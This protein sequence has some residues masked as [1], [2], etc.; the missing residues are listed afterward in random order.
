MLCQR[1]GQSGVFVVEEGRIV[2]GVRREDLDKAIGH[3]LA[4]APVRG[5]MS[6]SF[7]SVLEDATLAELQARVT[8][9]DDGRVDG[10][11]GERQAGGRRRQR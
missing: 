1:H 9:A 2:G 5:I 7:A 6:S 10:E 8:T 11:V 3:E 4:H